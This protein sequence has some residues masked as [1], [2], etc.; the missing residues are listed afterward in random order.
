MTRLPLHTTL[1]A[2]L[3][4]AAV[5]FAA[6][7]QADTLYSACAGC[8]G[9]DGVSH[10]SHMPTI[11]GLNFQYFYA[12]M[13]AYKKDQRPSTIMGRIAKG[14][15]SSKLQRMALHFGRKPWTGVRGDF[16]KELAK[17]GELLHDEYCEECHEDNGHYQ[18]RDTPPI[19]GQAKGYLVY[20]MIDYREDSEDLPRPPLM[21]SRLE[22]LSDDDLVALAEFYASNPPP[23][24]DG[25]SQD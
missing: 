22:K 9:T 4:S 24:T 1:R 13:R 17:R 3:T 11:Q 14:Y 25:E 19:A 18:D 16:D 6:T 5:V 2:L 10:S 20:Q 23:P 21:Q 12:T 8:H 7:A 15:R